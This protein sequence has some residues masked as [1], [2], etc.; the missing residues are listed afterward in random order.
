MRF[1]Y[2]PGFESSAESLKL[3]LQSSVELY[4]ADVVEV[5]MK[6]IILRS[7]KIYY[8]RYITAKFQTSTVGHLWGQ[9]IQV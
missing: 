2:F 9:N 8:L 1:A 3:F 5:L 4:F 6:R 7:Y